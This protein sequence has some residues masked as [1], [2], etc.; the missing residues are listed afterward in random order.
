MFEK[1]KERAEELEDSGLQIHLSRKK[2]IMIGNRYRIIGYM[3]D[4]M[5][6]ILYMIGSILFMTDADRVLSTSFFL[7]GSFFMISRAFI[8][9]GR[10]IH[11]KRFSREDFQNKEY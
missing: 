4:L 6:G 7:A 8:H 1:L 5:L 3:N 2:K 10:D 9:I 11:L